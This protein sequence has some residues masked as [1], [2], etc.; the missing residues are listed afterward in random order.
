MN[1]AALLVLLLCVAPAAAQVRSYAIVIGNNDSL[2]PGT[3]SLRYAD[4]D[5][6]RY[7]ELF[8]EFTVR[9]ELLTVL[10]AETQRVHRGLAAQSRPPTL[11]NLSATI[12]AFNVAM[13]QDKAAG[14]QPVL[15]VIYIGHGHIG[16]AGQGYVSLLDGPLTGDELATRVVGPSQ[17]AFNHLIFDACNSFLL[18]AQRG[19]VADDS[20]PDGRAAIE[21]YLQEQSVSRFPNTGLVMSTSTAKESHE[22]SVF[23]GGVFSQEVRSALAGAADVNADGLIEYSELDAFLAA[24]N[25]AVDDP[26]A[27]IEAFIQ[28]PRLDRN[29]PLVDLAQGHFEHFLRLPAEFSGRFHLEDA[30]GVRFGDGNKTAERDVFIALP[31]Q[32]YYFIRGE[33]WEAKIP[34]ERRGTVDLTALKVGASS[35]A[36]RGSIAE[37]FRDR[38]FQMPYGPG[39]YNGYVSRTRGAPAVEAERP[40]PPPEF[41]P[42]ASEQPLKNPYE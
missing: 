17:A 35:L 36:S 10:D 39:F 6:A 1:K 33:D 31:P 7:F 29:R 24:A 40:F 25:H 27:R 32:P 5:A 13:S 9:A 14:R 11:A 16:P 37:T 41:L 12:A 19:A 34:L 18:V 8:R 21:S 2:D 4:D 20:G 42:R 26:R 23:Q 38:L 28:P 30:R 15:Y 22:W 3:R